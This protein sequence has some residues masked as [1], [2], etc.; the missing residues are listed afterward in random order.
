MAA[1]VLAGDIGGTKTDLAVYSASAPRRLTLVREA[2]FPSRAFAS[3]EAVIAGFRASR[4][5]PIA[6]A[7]FGVP[8]PVVDGAAQITNLPW[9]VD[10]E[11]LARAVGS[12]RTRL[13]N[14]LE[15]TAYGAL[16]LGPHELLTVNRG[17]APRAGNRAVIAAGTG[18]GQ[19]VLFWDGSR[20]RPSA[21]EG[22]HADFGPIDDRDLGLWQFLRRLYKRVSWERVVSG[23]GLYNIFRY[24]DEELRRPVAP[25]VRARLQRDDPGAVIGA[26]GVGGACPTCAEAVT[27]FVRLY[28]AQA[29]N[30]ALTTMA[31]GGVYVGG[32]IVTKLLPKITGGAFV[33][34]FTAKEPHRA[35]VERIPVWILLNPRTSQLGAAYVAAELLDA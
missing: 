26:A 28:G 21:T 5:E 30:L 6:A 32:G 7:A 16:F 4:S 15:T 10:V 8:G 18:L 25:T 27:M 23:P 3:L 33:E 31:L 12:P 14:D 1:C 24:L 29:G 17:I 35:L 22:G 13:M 19:A 34:A 20:Y 2:S 9:R 11:M